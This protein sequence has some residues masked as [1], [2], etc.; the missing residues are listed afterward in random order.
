MWE[1]GGAL[2]DLDGVCVGVLDDECVFVPVLEEVCV[3]VAV[4]DFVDVCDLDR[5]R[6]W[7][8]WLRVAET[9]GAAVSVLVAVD[10][11]EADCEL[12]G[13]DVWV[14]VEV[15]MARRQWDGY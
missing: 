14:V 2:R 4:R 15:C 7:R 6:D 5:V 8:E 10:E 3:C 9:V 11:A 1:W 13:V 12:D